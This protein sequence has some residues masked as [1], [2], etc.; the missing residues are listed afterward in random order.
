MDVDVAANLKSV[1]ERIRKAELR[2]GRNP[3]SVKL[4][5]VTKKVP[6]ESI[7]KVINEG[8]SDLGENRV[9]ELIKKQEQL[10]DVKWHLIG[11][12]QTNKV[13]YVLGKTVLIHSLDRW[14]LAETISRMAVKKGLTADVLVQV[15]VSGEETKHG[16]LPEEVEDFVS[17][18]VKLPGLN[19]KGL[20]TMAPFVDNPEEVRP[21]FKELYKIKQKLAAKWPGIRL[22]SMGMTNDFEIAVEEGADLVRIG[23]A[24]FRGN[25]G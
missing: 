12:L 18:A 10:P 21:I 7:T 8:I 16:L 1:I 22:L 14:R 20:M 17:E 3:G 6:V 23:S 11:S 15:N 9:Q 13:K 2:S 4:V 24:I 19:I 25:T 5:A